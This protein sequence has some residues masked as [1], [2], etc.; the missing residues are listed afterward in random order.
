MTRVRRLLAAGS[1]LA[2]PAIIVAT[3]LWGE[4]GR[5]ELQKLQPNAAR[6]VRSLDENFAESKFATS[7]V[8][9][10]ETAQGDLLFALQVQPKLEAAP[11]R[12]RDVL[13]LV[14]TSASKALGAWESMKKLTAALAAQGAAQDRFAVWTVN[15]KTTK[16]NK[17]FQ[18]AN[19]LGEALKTLA[20]EYPSGVANLK[21]AVNQSVKLFSDSDDGRQKIV[22][23]LGDGNSL[24]N[25]LS[26]E[27]RTQIC[28]ELVKNEIAFYAIPLGIRFDS[29]NLHSLTTGS[30]GAVVRVQPGDLLEDTVKRFQAST[31][32]PVIYAKSLKF[33]DAG[34]VDVVPS[35]LPPLRA[36]TPTLV[37]G[38]AKNTTD[39]SYSIEGA[40]NGRDT[41]VAAV[42]TLPAAAGDNYFLA[43]MFKQWQAAK[44]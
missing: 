6:I 26:G 27:D 5:K 4:P 42:E 13:I 43:G 15:T 36:D 25:P 29:A 35:V 34:I 16:L 7:S 12:P 11:A 37:L 14:D 40:V 19:Q 28:K 10:Y 23:L 3:H 30:G 20:Q 18:P 38:K 39:L 31:A 41:S 44:D 2:I 32:V 1:F 8:L 9:A 22:A 24:A 33:K 17:G 21:D